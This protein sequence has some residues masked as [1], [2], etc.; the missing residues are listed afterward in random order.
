MIR[1]NFRTSGLHQRSVRKRSRQAAIRLPHRH[2]SSRKQ[3]SKPWLRL[4]L[5]RSV[6][7]SRGL[8]FGLRAIAGVRSPPTLLGVLNEFGPLFGGLNRI[9]TPFSGLNKYS[10]DLPKK[11]SVFGQVLHWNLTSEKSQGILCRVFRSRALPSVFWQVLYLR[12]SFH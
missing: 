5:A 9:W 4:L 2:D 7:R 6:D 1:H 12:V 8:S 10:K 3:A 11:F